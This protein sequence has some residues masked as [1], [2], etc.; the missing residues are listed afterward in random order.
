MRMIISKLIKHACNGLINC[1]LQ[2]MICYLVKFNISIF[3]KGV[4]FQ[5]QAGLTRRNS[6]AGLE[7]VNNLCAKC[8]CIKTIML[9]AFIFEVLFRGDFIKCVALP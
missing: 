7:K 8:F 1:Y 5:L 9:M 4:P 2:D 3:A 6:P